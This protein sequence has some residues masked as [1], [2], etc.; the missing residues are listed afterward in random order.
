MSGSYAL[1][2]TEKDQSD[3]ICCVVNSSEIEASIPPSAKNRFSVWFKYPGEMAKKVALKR[4]AKIALLSAEDTV[5]A[6]IAQTIEI[7]TKYIKN[8]HRRDYV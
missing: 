4:L 5:A 6:E 3:F 8:K 2:Y 7:E 1:A